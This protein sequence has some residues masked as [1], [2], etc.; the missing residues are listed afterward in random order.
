MRNVNK[1]RLSRITKDI[2]LIIPLYRDGLGF[3]ILDRG[4]GV[5]GA[6]SVL[7]GRKDWPYQFEFVQIRGA[8]DS[9]R[10]PAQTYRI[11]CIESEEEWKTILENCFNAGFHQVTPPEAYVSAKFPCVAYQDADG[12][13][14]VLVRGHW[15][16]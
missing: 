12:Y 10:D 15:K 1:L 6:D 13:K 14:V 3:E 8:Q 16:K 2:N 9:P 4:E 5:D 7:L 11:F